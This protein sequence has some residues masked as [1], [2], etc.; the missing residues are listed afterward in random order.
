MTRNEFDAWIEEHYR[1]LLKVAR[2]RVS[3][4]SKAED[5]VQNAVAG[6]LDSAELERREASA[7]W[8]WA[9]GFVRGA[10]SHALRAERREAEALD[11]AALRN[12]AGSLLYDGGSFAG[13][14]SLLGRFPFARGL[15]Y[16]GEYTVRDAGVCPRCS[17]RQVLRVEIGCDRDAK[18]NVHHVEAWAYGCLNGH[19]TYTDAEVL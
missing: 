9:A 5:V 15:S 18:G 14:R 11:K 4:D 8:P 19:R 10:A 6:M 16:Q 1:D 17:S 3:S 2:L 13:P 12:D 7:I